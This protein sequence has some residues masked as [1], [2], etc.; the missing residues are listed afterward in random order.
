[1]IYYNLLNR[2][3]RTKIPT[4]GYKTGHHLMYVP[5]VKKVVSNLTPRNVKYMHDLAKEIVVGGAQMTVIKVVDFF[6]HNFFLTMEREALKKEYNLDSPLGV[7][8][9]NNELEKLKSRVMTDIKEDLSSY[10]GTDY[11]IDHFSKLWDYGYLPIEIMAIEEGT[12]VDPNTPVIVFMNTEDDMF[13]L[14]NFLETPISSEFWK[15]MHSASMVYG[16]R[17]L[18]YKY[19]LKTDKDNIAFL[20]FQNHDFSFRGMQGIESA[21]SSGLGF[22][23]GTMGSDT[24]PVLSDADYY[25]STPNSVFSIFATEHAVQTSY[26]KELEEEGILHLIKTQFPNGNISLVSDSYD[27]FKI[28]TE[29]IYNLKEEILSRDG[30]VVFRGDSGDPVDIICGHVIESLPGDNYEEFL[31]IAK[32]VL[33][34]ELVEETPHGECGGD[35]SKVFQWENDGKYYKVTYSPDWNRHDKRFYFIDN[36]GDNISAVEVEYTPEMKGQIELL[37]ECFGGT[38]NDQ[39]YKVLNSK[40]GAIYGDGIN[41]DRAEEIFERLMKKGFASSNIVLG[42]GSFSLGYATRDNQGSAVKATYIEK[43]VVVVDEDGN[44]SHKTVGVDIFKDPKTD[45]G[46]RSRKGLLRV[47]RD[48]KTGGIVTEETCTWEQ[49]RSEENLLK[50]IFKD[51][52]LIKSTTLT[53]IRERINQNIQKEYAI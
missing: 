14:T 6:N 35:N 31:D 40:V 4:D 1:M 8:T 24:V 21:G 23:F 13:W 27:F 34:Q 2:R 22:A 30:K 44:E 15:P 53:E 32:D 41:F 43:T 20:E 36:Y 17:K 38:V 33:H 12:I 18:A 7:A 5:G 42:W 39:G 3:R 51:G 45:P 19:L 47:V 50:T 37:W 11:N 28:H 29:T 10:T 9:Y 25:Y 26:T 46:K 52:K 48:E 16:A 49:V